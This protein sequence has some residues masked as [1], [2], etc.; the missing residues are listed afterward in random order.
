YYTGT[1]IRSSGVRDI[2]TT[3]WISVCISAV[4]FFATFV[5]LYAIERIGRRVLLLIS[6]AGIIVSL[7]SMGTAFVIINNESAKVMPYNITALNNELGHG[8]ARCNLYRSGSQYFKFSNCD[9]CVTDEHCGFC[10][11]KEVPG[12]GI[13]APFSKVDNNFASYGPCSAELIDSNHEWAD[14][15]C[16]TKYTILPIIVMLIYL[17]FFAIGFGPLPWALNAE[18]YPTWARGTCAFFIYAG[19]TCITF[20]F[21]YIFVPETKGYNIEE[22]EMLFMSK[23]DRKKV[24][25]AQ[26]AF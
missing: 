23:K 22:I 9:F 12:A 18:F 15:Y 10:E 5:P 24:T 21:S 1:I 8:A 11:P 20:I 17:V 6:V 7:I 2:Q 25:S 16:H 14:N 4:N 19:I 13:C 3:I 26:Q